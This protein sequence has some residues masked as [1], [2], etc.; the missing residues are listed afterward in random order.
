MNCW[1]TNLVLSIGSTC[2]LNLFITILIFMQQGSSSNLVT[3]GYPMLV[4]ATTVARLMAYPVVPGISICCIVASRAATSG[5]REGA[6]SGKGTISERIP[7]ELSGR[8][9]L[10]GVPV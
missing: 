7:G 5:S 3:S 8:G 4:I 6:C 1:L 10:R 2:T 9:E